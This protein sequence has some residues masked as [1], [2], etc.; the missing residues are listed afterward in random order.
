[1]S[2]WQED[3]EWIGLDPLLEMAAKAHRMVRASELVAVRAM[4][5]DMRLYAR[6]A[7]F[8]DAPGPCDCGFDTVLDAYDRLSAT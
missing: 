4:L 6:H 2:G 5:H 3:P 8:C 7:P 1:M